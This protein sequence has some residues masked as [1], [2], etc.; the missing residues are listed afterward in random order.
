MCNKIV[1][2]WFFDFVILMF[3][4]SNSIM[5]AFDDPLVEGSPFPD[6]VDTLYLAVYTAEMV[7]KIIAYG[8][9]FNNGAYLRGLWNILDFIIVSSAYLPYIINSSTVNLKSLRALRVLRPLRTISKVEKLRLLIL[10]L[11]SVFGNLIETLFVLI[12]F[13]LIFAIGG[14]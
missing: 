4:L 1:S 2:H 13:L 7:L 9:L 3:I 11:V 10:T 5:L 6:W 8:F 12:F 14:L